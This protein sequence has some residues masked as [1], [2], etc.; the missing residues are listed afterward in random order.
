MPPFRLLEALGT[1]CCD[2]G[3]Q[4]FVCVASAVMLVS[5]FLFVGWNW[6]CVLL[7]CGVQLVARAS[8][9]GCNWLHVLLV[10]GATGYT[11][12]LCGVRLATRASCVGCNWLQML[13]VCGESAY[14]WNANTIEPASDWCLRIAGAMC[15]SL[16]S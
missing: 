3:E 6:L 9:V 15:L 12:F 7:V 14:K 11:C 13:L 8:C 10:W 4:L 5:T 1:Q 2:A 16:V